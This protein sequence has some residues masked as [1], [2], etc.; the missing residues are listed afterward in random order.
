MQ[1][2]TQTASTQ[3]HGS[4]PSGPD[5]CILLSG[6]HWETYESLLADMQDSHAAHFAYDRGVLEIRAPSYES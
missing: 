6:I 4:Q 1:T 3:V 2:A 5:H